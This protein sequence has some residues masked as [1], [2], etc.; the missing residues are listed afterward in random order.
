[1]Q[2]F[3]TLKLTGS[4]SLD[5]GFN[6]LLAGFYR[7][8]F[9]TTQFA[10]EL[11]PTIDPELLSPAVTTN[12]EEYLLSSPISRSTATLLITTLTSYC[13]SS[14]I[15]LIS[16]LCKILISR[17]ELLESLFILIAPSTILNPIVQFLESFHVGGE[18]SFGETNPIAVYGTIVLSLQVILS[19]FDLNRDLARHLASHSGFYLNWLASVSAVYPLQ[20]M[21]QDSTILIRGWVGALFSEGISDELM[22]STNPRILLR[23]APTLVKQSISAARVGV[24][25]IENLREGLSYFLQDSLLSYTIPGIV[26]WLVGEIIRAA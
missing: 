7:S 15:D 16:S 8:G 13:E 24:L 3:Q 6:D 26:K 12:I 19:R 2:E 4:S 22:Q 10:V 9:I 18:E 17:P 5:S 23:I 14:S 1:M 21:D 20:G 11:S 25:S